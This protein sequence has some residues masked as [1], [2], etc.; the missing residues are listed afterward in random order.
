[1][2]RRSTLPASEDTSR[3]AIPFV[4]E[5]IADDQGSKDLSSVRRARAR[6]MRPILWRL[7]FIGGFLAG[8]VVISLAITGILFA[9][10]PQI[11]DLRF[12]SIMHASDGPADR[13]LSEQTDAA[14]AAHPD[15]AIT[16]V[17]PAHDGANTMF[18]MEEHVA[19]DGHHGFGP[20]PGSLQVYVDPST[21]EHTGSIDPEE[22]SGNILRSWHSSWSLGP[23][24]EPVT[25][26]AGSWFLVAMVS[27][28]YLWW[29]GLRKRGSNALGFRRGLRGRLRSKELHNAIGLAFFFPMVFLVITGL[30]WTQFSGDR[31]SS[32]S[33]SVATERLAVET[34]LADP[35]PGHADLANLDTVQAQAKQADIAIPQ[36][37]TVP[38]DDSTA[39]RV[40]TGKVTY[41][42]RADQLAVEGASGEVVDFV[43]Y[44]DEHWLNKLRTAGMHFHQAE[45]FGVWTQ[46]LMTALAL[47]IIV[48]VVAGYKMWWQRRP[49][50]GMGTPPPVRDW[51][52]NAPFTLLAATAVLIWVLPTL[53]LSLAVWLVLESGWRWARA[54]RAGGEGL[55]ASPLQ[56]AKVATLSVLGVAML[57]R[58]D[59]GQAAEDPTTI[60]R[61]L[62]YGWSIPLGTVLIAVALIGVAALARGAGR[63]HDHT[64][65]DE[66]RTEALT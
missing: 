12:G 38:T 44:S 40:T 32:A 23:N 62:V 39:W 31:V 27:G 48:M 54:A 34:G 52:R 61:L 22:L 29:P 42:L 4:H 7:H 60:Q 11:D 13:T 24:V 3:D 36:V 59:L 9:F 43:D 56:L 5:Q 49:A 50:G 35:V 21:G 46:L 2:S 14:Q 55:S 17:T 58:P 47:L 64:G 1:M 10:N 28:V 65:A 66:E 16:S 45:L 33:D 26:L 51:V 25:E 30:A 20:P 37:I 41:P 19:G 8:P 18:Q 6:T 57:A 15:L 53:G 63:R